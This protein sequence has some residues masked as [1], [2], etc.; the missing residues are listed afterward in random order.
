MTSDYFRRARANGR[1]S[2]MCDKHAVTTAIHCQVLWP[3]ANSNRLD[4]TTATL[5]L[6]AADAI[7]VNNA[8]RRTDTVKHVKYRC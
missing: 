2:S 7:E 8:E 3:I 6:P 1:S 5:Q 4:R